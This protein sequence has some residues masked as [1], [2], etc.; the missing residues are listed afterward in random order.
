MGRLRNCL[1]EPSIP[2]RCTVHTPMR[3]ALRLG[4]GVGKSGYL[5]YLAPMTASGP[6][7]DA[8]L[9][10]LYDGIVD[11]GGLERALGLLA[12]QF[13]CP[14]AALISFDAAAPEADVVSSAGMFAEPALQRAYNE[15]WAPLDPAPR[16]FAALSFGSAAS[17]GMLFDAEYLRSWLSSRSFFGRAVSRNAWAPISPRATAISRSSACSAGPIVAPSS[18]AKFRRWKESRRISGARC[19]CAGPSCGSASRSICSSR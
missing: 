13:H 4:Q 18:A 15:E 19:S 7:S 6:P 2:C 9:A 5:C 17:T 8:L 12:E 10:A 1:P 14:S 11:A 3:A 16:A